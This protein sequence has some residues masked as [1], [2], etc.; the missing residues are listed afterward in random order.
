M[1]F[2]EPQPRMSAAAA[3]LLSAVPSGV[4]Q[5]AVPRERERRFSSIELGTQPMEL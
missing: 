1:A 5:P 4:A 3:G 2:A